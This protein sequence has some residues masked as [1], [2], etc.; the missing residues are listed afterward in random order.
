MA[1]ER[2]RGTMLDLIDTQKLQEICR[3][4]FNL[5]YGEESAG[6]NQLTIWK[7]IAIARDGKAKETYYDRDTVLIC[8]EGV[9]WTV[10]ERGLILVPTGD[11]GGIC[12]SGEVLQSLKTGE[13]IDLA[14]HI[15]TF[16]DR[17]ENNFDLWHHRLNMKKEATV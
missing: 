10:E 15:R 16:G 1:R 2:E 14:D 11:S 13:Q 6:K 8:S 3:G 9:G 17:L 5:Q 7:D 4:I 12:V